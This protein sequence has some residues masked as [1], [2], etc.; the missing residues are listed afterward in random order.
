MPRN[1]LYFFFDRLYLGI[2]SPRSELTKENNWSNFK[3]L[4]A[5]LPSTFIGD[6]A[7]LSS[8]VWGRKS[9]IYYSRDKIGFCPFR[10]K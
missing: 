7:G 3:F 4:L 5:I 1:W 10:A 2:H 9:P 6:E 8:C